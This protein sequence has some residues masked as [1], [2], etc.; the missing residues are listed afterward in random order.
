MIK[1]IIFDCGCSITVEECDEE[2]TT[3]TYT[4]S[5]KCFVNMMNNGGCKA[6]ISF[7]EMVKKENYENLQW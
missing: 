7:Q 4:R 3:F 1:Q 5:K 6:F 2:K